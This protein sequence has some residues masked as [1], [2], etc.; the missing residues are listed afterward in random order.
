MVVAVLVM[1]MGLWWAGCDGVA[2]A[3]AVMEVGVTGLC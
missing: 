1:V 2:V 3:G